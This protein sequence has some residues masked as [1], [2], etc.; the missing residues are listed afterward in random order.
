M[1]K[2]LDLV[3][4]G[5]CAD[6]V[7]IIDENRIIVKHGL[8]LLSNGSKPGIKALLNSVGLSDKSLSVMQIVFG[9]AP[10]IN[11]AG[12]LGDANR[13][14]EL[15]TTKDEKRAKSLANELVS[16]NQKRQIIQQEVVDAA[17]NIIHANIDLD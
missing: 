6:M 13:S 8:E 9:V 5:T 11:A 2:Y 14:V 7:P 16:E 12:R 10:K 4:L 17:F 3:T 15:L 1:H